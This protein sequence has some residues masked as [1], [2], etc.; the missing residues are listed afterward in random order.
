MQENQVLRNLLGNLSNFIGDGAGGLLPKLGWDLNDFNNFVNRSES[1]TAW[2]SYQRH[3]REEGGVTS[4]SGASTSQKRTAP[5][6]EP[7]YLRAKRPRGASE[8][9]GDSISL[10]SNPSA[11]VGLNG[12]YN[13]STRSVND[14]TLFTELLR[15]SSG[16]G[17]TPSPVTSS[18]QF[19]SAA[20]SGLGSTYSYL[21]PMNI[22]A[23][24]ALPMPLVN[25]SPILVQGSAKMPPNANARAR[26]QVVPEESDEEPKRM[27]AY[28][29]IQCAFSTSLVVL[30]MLTVWLL[31]QLSPRELQ[32]KLSILS[33]IIYTAN[34]RAEVIAVNL[35]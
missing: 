9:N 21:P 29:L 16:F 15:G 35:L 25:Q 27:E 17:Q 34:T 20:G 32:T 6:D 13:S 30:K 19:A 2:E 10:V 11:H 18:N 1:D 8:A 24:G 23:D 12:I 14:H 3:K 22:N 31:V 7:I 5:T 4:S 33:T 26:S 28:K